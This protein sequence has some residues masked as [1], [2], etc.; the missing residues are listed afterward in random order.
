M[1]LTNLERDFLQRLADDAWTSPPLFDH[2][3]ITRLVE[4]G[5]VNARLLSGGSV[6]YEVTKAGREALSAR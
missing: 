6:H 1:Q 5:F 2:G 4:A 3:L